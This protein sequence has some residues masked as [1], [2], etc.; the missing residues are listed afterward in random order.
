MI[1][2]FLVGHL[3]ILEMWWD[4][5]V[6][7]VSDL[8]LQLELHRS[9]HLHHSGGVGEHERVVLKHQLP[10]QCAGSDLCCLFLRLVS[11]KERIKHA[12]KSLFERQNC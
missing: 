5:S 1:A 9:V 11:A 4:V 8:I 7:D 10:S 3:L 12:C 6:L 2:C